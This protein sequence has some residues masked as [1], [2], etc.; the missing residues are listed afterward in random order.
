M[1]LNFSANIWILNYCA[2]RILYLRTFMDEFGL[3]SLP[4]VILCVD[5]SLDFSKNS[6]LYYCKILAL[7]NLSGF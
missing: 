7:K 1:E 4:E 6:I 2:I 5:I 3:H